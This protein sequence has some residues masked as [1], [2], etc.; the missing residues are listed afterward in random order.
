MQS[1]PE[2]LRPLLGW[3]QFVVWFATPDVDRPGK[4][5]KL[6]CD[7]RTGVVHDA[8][9]PAIWTDGDTALAAAAQWDK[10][11]GYGVGFV[12]TE[13]DPFFFLD[14]DNCLQDDGHWS[15]IAIDLCA[16]FPGAAVEI[17]HSGRGLHIFGIT[18]PV[19]H[20][21]R[22]SAYGLELYTSKRYV[23]LTGNGAQGSILTDCT[24]SFMTLAAQYFPENATSATR[25]NTWTTEPVADWVGP[26]DDDELIRKALRSNE[27]S[28]SARFGGATSYSFKDLWEGNIADNVRSEADQSLANHLAFWTGKNCE[29][30]ESLMRRSG[31]VRDKWDARGHANYLTN[32]ILKACAYVTKVLQSKPKA[33]AMPADAQPIATGEVIRRCAANEYV[34]ASDQGAY[35]DGCHYIADL[36]KVFVGP[37]NAIYT[38]QAFDVVYGGHQFALDV[39]GSKLTD[40]AFEALTLSRANEPSIV[41]ALCFRPELAPG[42]VIEDGVRKYVNSYVPYHAPMVEGDPTPFLDLIARMLPND[43]D[44]T[45]L[46]NYLASM[47]QNPGV[48]FQWWPVLQGVEGNGKTMIIQAMSYIMGEHY[49]HLP[50]AHAMA[51]DGLKFNS[52][53]ER[54]LFIGIEEVRLSHKRD[55]LDEFKVIVTNERI[56]SEGKGTN[57]T[58]TDN[59]ANGILCTNHPDGVPIDQDNRR[60]AMFFTAQQTLEDLRR[61]GMTGDY[62]P[63]LYAW[64]KGAGRGIIAHYLKTF[65]LAAELDPAQ[66]CKRAPVTS[67]RQLAISMSLGRVEQEILEAIDNEQLG[68]IGGWVSSHYLNILID[69]I[70]AYVP[71]TKRRAMMQSLG[72]DYHPVLRDGRVNNIVMPDNCKPRLYIRNGHLHSQVT[73]VI[74]AE[75]L[76]SKA[77]EKLLDTKANAVFNVN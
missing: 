61:D 32:T 51:R 64:F 27:K 26:V 54:K 33:K 12:F 1:L 8:H 47:A 67:S 38:K 7:Y 46:I 18:Q 35:F 77:Q 23:A 40:S 57:Q 74:A 58:N 44:R 49:T 31:L 65:P 6:P 71:H 14:I 73:Q 68:F 56:P 50:N 37:K 28:A 11:F 15:P 63:K 59:R 5:K 4:F 76:Y 13:A 17:S 75:S 48:K 16:R 29:R 55:F 42:T 25:D 72:Y 21:T 24:Q 9:T 10:G 45:L 66:L 36:H 52:W 39:S 43:H 60:Y 2:A 22:N 3:R 53:I 20:G 70:K 34:F 19:P 62:F 69:R 30:I 41:D